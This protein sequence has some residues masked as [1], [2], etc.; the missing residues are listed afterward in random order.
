VF[1]IN[2]LT[3]NVNQEGGKTNLFLI[4]GILSCLVRGFNV[5]ICYSTLSRWIRNVTNSS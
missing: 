2:N 5:C 4:L 1:L 3:F